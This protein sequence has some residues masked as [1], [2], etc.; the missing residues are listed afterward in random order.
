MK[1]WN[2]L[3]F[4]SYCPDT[5]E[6]STIESFYW[7]TDCLIDTLFKIEQ[8]GLNGTMF[9]TFSAFETPLERHKNC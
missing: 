2:D 3:N 7:L 4:F 8:L 1:T 5:V 9:A 6:Y